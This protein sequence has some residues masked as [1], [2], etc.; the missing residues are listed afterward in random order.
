MPFI[1]ENGQSREVSQQEF[2]A[3]AKAT[4]GAFIATDEADLLITGSARLYWRLEL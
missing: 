1:Y 4:A 2:I 3:F